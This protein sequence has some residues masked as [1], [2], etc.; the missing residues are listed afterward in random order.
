MN[1]KALLT[2][3]L[4]LHL[5]S[6]HS[7]CGNVDLTGLDQPVADVL[8]DSLTGLS[9]TI[10]Q[11]TV[12][13]EDYG[14]V[15]M[16]LH[17]QGLHDEALACYEVAE[18]MSFG[19][20]RWPYLAG[21]SLRELGEVERSL[22]KFRSAAHAQPG[23]APARVY[24][25]ELFRLSGDNSAAARLL[26]PLSE[27]S[28]D[29]AVAAAIGETA[30]SMRDFDAAIEWLQRALEAV[31]A[32]TRLNYLL[33]QAYLAKGED[34]LAK[35]HLEEAGAVGVKPVDPILSA[36]EARSQGD[37]ALVL[38][39]RRAFAARD[40]EA[41]QEAFEQALARN[42]KNQAARVNLAVARANQGTTDDAIEL[43]EAVLTENPDNAAAL[44]N[45]GGLLEK[46]NPE[47]SVQH[48]SALIGTPSE[49]GELHLRLGS[50]T[51]S[52]GK[53]VEAIGH[54]ELARRDQGLFEPASLALASLQEQT[55]READ[56]I[57]LLKDSLLVAPTSESLN[58]ELARLLANAADK[59]LREGQLSLQLSGRV[60]K[61]LPT[62][63][64]ARMM[65]L[66][67]AELG[68]CKAA[69]QW[70]QEAASLVE[71]NDSRRYELKKFA[72]AI[73]DN[74]CRP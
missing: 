11:N 63:K 28:R 40:F 64:S 60:H 54:F 8:A 58:L 59:S 55:D 31:P 10:A 15:G 23:F 43:L 41:A 19:D 46:T 34:K 42:P 47:Q 1:N 48:Y 26:R 37:I 22:E 68:D 45:L 18:S 65:A 24:L 50:V 9:T 62:E 52:L 7:Q 38:K 53:T 73:N 70:L 33:G 57:Q 12:T 39:G 13:S 4:I 30:L 27:T 67:F 74:D 56:A 61:N 16:Q 51:A 6:A 3:G 20:I 49:D 44:F 69:R 36:V 29:A 66:G 71:A 21:H 25:A 17:A 2:L 35:K 14:E 32:A 5:G 72:E